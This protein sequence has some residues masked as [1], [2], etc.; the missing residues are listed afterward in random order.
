MQSSKIP[1]SLNNFL[2]VVSIG[3]C[4]LSG[5]RIRNGGGAFWYVI[6]GLS[7]YFL[8]AGLYQILFKR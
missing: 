2:I 4:L 6:L 7:G 5:L 1:E 3:V 8:V